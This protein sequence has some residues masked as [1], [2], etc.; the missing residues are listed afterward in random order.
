MARSKKPEK[1]ASFKP[2]RRLGKE[3]KNPRWFVPVMASCY[4]IGLAWILVYYISAGVYPLPSGNTNLFVGFGFFFV[5][6]ML[7]TRWK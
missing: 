2:P 3:N 6:F 7:T 1:P 4:L 5:G